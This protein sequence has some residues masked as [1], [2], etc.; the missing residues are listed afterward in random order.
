MYDRLRLPFEMRDGRFFVCVFFNQETKMSS[1]R[2][3]RNRLF[4]KAS[5]VLVA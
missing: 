1:A 3:N 5:K 2:F 4:Y